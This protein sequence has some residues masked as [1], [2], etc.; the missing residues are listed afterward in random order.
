MIRSCRGLAGIVLGS[1]VVAA[2]A[3]AAPD[4]SASTSDAV[5]TD[6]SVLPARA[7]SETDNQRIPYAFS[8]F[9]PCA[10]G[11]LG[12]VVE[13]EGTLHVVFH[14]TVNSAGAYHSRMHFQPQGIG[15]TGLTTGDK[16]RATGVTQT[17]VNE[18]AGL[19]S[20]YVNNFR[21]VGQGPGNNFLIHQN[22][23]VTFTPDGRLT[24]SV[25]NLSIECK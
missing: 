12:E 2:C 19:T 6:Q 10:A 5:A 3:D 8:A 4:P 18:N 1:A 21:L 13:F 15:G 23:H 11:G 25:D 20:T 14:V 9:V 24:A 7:S 16:Y 22:V 17:F